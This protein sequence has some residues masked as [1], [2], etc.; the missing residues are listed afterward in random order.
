MTLLRRLILFAFISLVMMLAGINLA[1]GLAK[2]DDVHVQLAPGPFGK[3]APWV[4][5]HTANGQQAE[6][7]VVLADQADLSGAETLPTKLDKG[8]F[9]YET[10]FKTAQA[11]QGP[12]LQW[13]AAHGVEHRAYYIVNLI[14][15]KGDRSTAMALAN[16]SDVARIDGNPQ[17]RVLPERPVSLR[18][19]SFATKQ[20][21]SPSGIASQTALA[22]TPLTIE[23]NITYVHAPQVWAMGYTGQGI[24]VGGQDTGYDWTHPALQ[25]HYRGWNGITATHDYNWHDSIHSSTGSCGANSTQ[26]C[27]DYGHGSHTMGTAVG[28]DSAA[29]GANQIGMA[30]GAKWIGCRN[31]NGGVGSPATYLE[32]FEFFLA[33]YPVGGTPAQGDPSKAPDVTNNSWGCPIGPPPGGEDCVVDSLLAAVQAQRAAGI[34]TVVSAGNSGPSCSTVSDPPAYHAEVFTVGALNTGADSIASFSSRGPVTADGSNRRKPDITAP[35]TNIRSSVPGGGYAS[36]GWS[37]TSMAGPHVAGAVALLWSARPQLKNHITETEQILSASAVHISSATCDTPG[38]TWPNNTYGYGRLDV[39]AAVDL[40]PVTDSTLMGIVRDTASLPVA[41]AL[42]AATASLTQTG[43]ATTS[44][45]GAYTLA[46]SSGVYTLTTSAYGYQTSIITGVNVAANVTTTQNITLTSAAFYTVS[47]MIMD[48]L[49][50]DP[51]SATIAIT[52]YPYSPI[53][54]DPVTGIYAVSLAEGITYTF[55]VK[56]IAAGY[57]PITRTVGPLTADQLED[58]ELPP[59]RIT[60]LPETLSASGAPGAIV[61]YTLQAE[62]MSNASHTYT[63]TAASSWPIQL[64]I[65]TTLM[66]PQQTVALLVSVTV[67]MTATAGLTDVATIVMTGSNGA[68]RSELTTSAYRQRVYLPILLTP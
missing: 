57:E 2:S 27:D 8:R 40:A 30:P 67:P 4:I 11:T 25:P 35:G 43:S 9:V 6:F 48:A 17:I 55:E 59:E 10:L 65:T 13:L 33:P 26:P 38:T 68:A 42:V 14:W 63:T 54:N 37:G 20:S 58:F 3:I 24:V 45:S 60:L 47:G 61:T 32:C 7:L 51:L 5:E 50:G 29:G 23:P 22:M 31:M 56:A 64:S 21:P 46:L 44:A 19:A 36:A 16:R 41:G 62:N 28:L 49:M 66:S 12:I 18:G 39:K 52:G 15:V 1:Q 53:A 34:M